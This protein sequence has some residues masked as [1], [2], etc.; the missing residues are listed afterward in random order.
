MS[1]NQQSSAKS[2]SNA[3]DSKGAHGRDNNKTKRKNNNKKGNN[4]ANSQSNKFKGNLPEGTLPTIQRDG[5]R[6]SQ[7]RIFQER[8]IIYASDNDMAMCP[9]A[10]R[11]LTDVIRGDYLDKAPDYTFY[12]TTVSV[13]DADGA[14]YKCVTS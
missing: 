11:K 9:R 1:T 13:K 14:E 10:I 7:F 5:N 6:T 8:L 2:S 3:T 4:Q 12:S